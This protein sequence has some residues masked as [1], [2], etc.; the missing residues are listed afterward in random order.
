MRMIVISSQQHSKLYPLSSCFSSSHSCVS[1]SSSSQRCGGG[2]ECLTELLEWTKEGEE[3]K[4]EQGL[5]DYR[6]DHPGDDA[7]K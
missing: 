6:L 7:K 5:H 4:K 1:A 3:V 2:E